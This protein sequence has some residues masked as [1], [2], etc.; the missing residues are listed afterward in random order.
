MTSTLPLP[1]D[2]RLMNATTAL[3]VTGLVLAG[4]SAGLWWVLRN[5]AFAIRQI[6]VAGDTTHNSAASL[7]AAVVP[8]LTGNFFT[9]DLSAAQVA[10]QSAPWVRQAVVQREFPGRLN[11]RLQEHRAV[12]HWGEDDTRLVNSFGEV[13][14]AAGGNDLDERDMPVLVGPEGQAPRLIEMHRMLNPLVAPLDTHVAQLALRPRGN[15]Q[16]E[17]DSGAVVELGHGTPQALAARLTQFVGTVKEV[18]ARHQRAVDAVEAADLRHAGGYAL[19][20]RGVTTVRPD[21]QP[22][23]KR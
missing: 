2:V 8:S 17:L 12:A 11:V 18:A 16:V 22:A 21:A 3:L 4:V 1:I 7:R 20:L 15:W 5:P 13:F 23:A 6:V 14:D 9:L 10:F 19:R